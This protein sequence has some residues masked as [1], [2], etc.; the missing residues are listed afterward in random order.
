MIKPELK[1][2]RKRTKGPV[3]IR[4]YKPSS[5]IDCIGKDKKY[6]IETYGCQAN[7]ADSERMAG[8]LS[9]VGYEAADCIERADIVIL[10]TCAIR[11]NAEKRVYGEIGRIM[12]Y[13]A[14]NPDLIVA[15]GGC[16]PQ[17]E[18][19]VEKILKTKNRVD[20]LFGTHNIERL[21]EMIKERIESGKMV[22]EVLSEEGDI[23]EKIPSVRNHPFKAWVDITYGC[24]EFCTYCIVPYTRGKER[25]RQIED[26]VEEVSQLAKKGYREVTLLGQNVN[27]YGLDYGDPEITFA[28]L[29]DKLNKLPIERIRFMT[30]HPKDFTDELIDI[31]AKGGN[32]MPFIHLPVQS[33][34][35][36]ILSK[37]NRKYTKEQY[38]ELVNKIKTKIP[39]ISLTTDIIVGFPGETE[40]DFQETLDLV[41]KAGFEGAYTFIYSKRAGTPAASMPDDVLAETKRDRLK[42]LNELVNRGYASG[43]RRFLDTTTEVLVEG[44]SKTDATK[45]CG[46][47]PNNKLVNFPGNPEMVGKTVSVNI[48]KAN[49]WSLYGEVTDKEANK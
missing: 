13:K 41:K 16:M 37:M 44:K 36:A 42:R 6:F 48:T 28:A 31:L 15:L 49:T 14:A 38:L 26:I 5:G 40:A 9:M 32:L 17:E 34:S 25:S 45:Y 3:E 33:G 21:P 43:T 47:N 46:Y 22:V 27:S 35:N 39:G 20:I 8:L 23:V 4:Q 10:N 2:A 12:K 18:T 29:L 7:E 30:S 24:D 11:E 19:T 1:S